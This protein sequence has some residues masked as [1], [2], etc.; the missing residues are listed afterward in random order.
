MNGADGGSPRALDGARR[1][2]AARLDNVGDVVLL[3]AALREIK[4]EYPDL[5]VTL[6]ASPGGAKA[7]PLLGPRVDEVWEEKVVWQDVGHRMPFDPARERA[8][9]GRLEK[10]RFDAAVV[11]T[12]FS[13]TPYALGYAAYLAGIPVR[14]GES[15]EFGGSVLS[16]PVGPF[17]VGM[18]QAER[19]LAH[20]RAVGVPVRD[21]RIE[22]RVPP[23][24][25]EEADALLAGAGVE[26]GY[27]LL[28][29]GASA[30]A[31]RYEGFAE[32]AAL[33]QER[34]VVTGAPGKAGL[35]EEVAG[36][37]HVSLAGKTSVPGLAALVARSWLVVTT[38]TGTL[39]LAEALGK[40][41]VVLYSGTDLPSQ[42]RP[43]YA[44]S[45]LLY[46][47]VP[48]SP[49]YLFA[50]PIGKPCL[51]VEPAEVVGAV[52]E[53]SGEIRAAR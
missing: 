52:R 33:L 48:C 47:E 17:A 14:I 23:W 50:C 13:Q 6:L 4:R 25:V 31:R 38:N 18:H 35:A 34:A 43:R 8:F 21:D 46:R 24:A 27:V 16:H 37:R 15:G 20:V 22:V 41:T 32:V 28:H 49:C 10:G 29:P 45:R 5:H 1:L 11:F 39:H 40:P 30:E 26:P 53:L 19:A 36:S 2:L 7:A 51:A 12:S 9:V 42:W 44:P 3:S